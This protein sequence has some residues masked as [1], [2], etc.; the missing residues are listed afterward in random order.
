MAITH[1][2][3]TTYNGGAGQMASVSRTFTG[4]GELRVYEPIPAASTDLAVAFAVDREAIV[5]LAIYCNK[6]V[7]I[8][9]NSS[10]SPTDTIALAA[11]QLIV[12]GDD[13]DAL[14]DMV[15]TADVTALYV[16]NAGASEATLRIEALTDVTP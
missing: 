7:T 1:R 12:W 14:A 4:G 13:E 5:S 11:G 2:I 3:G 8:K 6:A 9:T 10:S 15:F 16:T